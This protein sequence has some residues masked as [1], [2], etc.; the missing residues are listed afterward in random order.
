M[1]LR[2][3]VW[4]DCRLESSRSAGLV[5]FFVLTTSLLYRWHG[6]ASRSRTASPSFH[7]RGL[8]SLPRNRMIRL[9][10]CDGRGLHAHDAAASS[11][12][13]ST[14]HLERVDP[15]RGCSAPARRGLLFGNHFSNPVILVEV[16]AYPSPAGGT[17]SFR[18]TVPPFFRASSP[19]GLRNASVTNG[20][21]RRSSLAAQQTYVKI[22]L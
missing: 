4:L 10:Q 14:A 1:R 21:P 5:V 6:I 15:R 3:Y 17:E 19:L 8:P 2:R 18:P 16:A 13:P 22:L 7:I 11:V 9:C 12:A 20:A